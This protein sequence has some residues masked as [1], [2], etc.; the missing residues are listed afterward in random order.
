MTTSRIG[1]RTAVKKDGTL[2]SAELVAAALM[3]RSGV[4]SP[5]IRDCPIRAIGSGAV[6][7]GM[8]ITRV[9]LQRA[10]GHANT[11]RAR[12]AHR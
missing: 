2:Q 12:L 11:E 7:R 10:G 1:I 6:P 5:S 8:R 3:G 9:I 4:F